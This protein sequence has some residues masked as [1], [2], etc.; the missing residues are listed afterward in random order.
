MVKRSSH[1]KADFVLRTIEA[2]C[3]RVFA[4]ATGTLFVCF[5]GEDDSAR[6]IARLRLFL[7][8]QI[9]S[10]DRQKALWRRRRA[11]RA[12]RY[13]VYVHRARAQCMPHAWAALSLPVFFRTRS[14]FLAA[15]RNTTG[16]APQS[17]RG[18]RGYTYAYS[19]AQPECFS[20]NVIYRGNRLLNS[21]T[22]E[23]CESELSRLA[24]ERRFI[25]PQSTYTLSEVRR[26]NRSKKLVALEQTLS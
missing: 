18:E 10:F 21:R 26:L 17:D 24:Q 14:H 3:A 25:Y 4:D 11:G 16:S 12:G 19:R 7:R 23:Y 9:P 22:S 20:C 1:N 5:E 6:A 13:T 15:V 8:F 2:P